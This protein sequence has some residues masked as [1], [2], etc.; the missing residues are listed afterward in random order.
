MI[1]E[2]LNYGKLKSMH[3]QGD[4]ADLVAMMAEEM[5]RSN[6]KDTQN[7]KADSELSSTLPPSSPI[8]MPG[9]PNFNMNP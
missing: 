8:I 1:A 6:H 3:K 5:V 2:G 7:I 9:N 4:N